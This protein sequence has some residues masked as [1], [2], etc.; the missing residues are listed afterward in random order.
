MI[1]VSETTKRAYFDDSYDKQIVIDFENE[2]Q[3]K[4]DGVN[5]YHGDLWND[6][7]SLTG[8]G[9][10][11]TLVKF[12]SNSYSD[13]NN[14]SNYVK[15]EYFKCRKKGNI[16]FDLM[17]FGS[18]YVGGEFRLEVLYKKNDGKI[19]QTN[20]RNE[21]TDD[22]YGKGIKR[23]CL[24]SRYLNDCSQIL[25]IRIRNM[26]DHYMKYNVK[27]GCFGIFA[28]N[29]IVTDEYR[30]NY[31]E[32]LSDYSVL[33]EPIQYDPSLQPLTNENLKAESFSLTESLCSADNLK[34]GLCESSFCEFSYYGRSEKFR[35]KTINVYQ[36][37]IDNTNY[38]QG[39]VPLGRFKITSSQKQSSGGT[40]DARKIVAYDGLLKLE[41]NAADWYTQYMF[42]VNTSARATRFGFEYARQIFSTY[43]N[44]A[45]SIGIEEDADYGGVERI[46]YRPYDSIEPVD[47]FSEPFGTNRKRI[48]YGI[49][50]CITA[51][52]R[53]FYKVKRS[54]WMFSD[55][56]VFRDF[57]DGYKEEIDSLGRG[58]L[59]KGSILIEEHR[60]SGFN[61]FVVDADDWFAIHDDTDYFNVYVTKRTVE[62][63]GTPLR[64]ITEEVEVYESTKE[65]NLTNAACRL[66]YYNWSS[67]EIF[68]CDSSITGR[69]VIRS[70]LEVCGCFYKLDRYGK[71]QFKY[72]TK[73]ALYPSETLYPK[74]TLFTRGYEGIFKNAQ[75][76]KF[77]CEDYTVQDYGKI[78]IK[79]NSD[80]N[81]TKSIVEWQYVGDSNKKNAYI[82]EDNIFYCHS[83]MEYEYDS[84]AEVSEMLENMYLRIADMGYVPHD[85]D[86]VGMPYLECG[87]R[88]ILLTENGGIETFIFSRNLSGIQSMQDNFEAKGDEYNEQ[89]NDFGYSEWGNT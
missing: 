65:N 12:W 89:I 61:R 5:L 64:R 73:S 75:Y 22:F 31:I 16:I 77:D 28:T 66:M 62:Q 27:V 87:D 37:L 76:I 25:E 74:D 59:N 55:D 15:C 7:V 17:I 57:L 11:N 39:C 34:F 6:T 14:F 2:N 45:K 70:L 71:P 51:N 60:T 86:A 19:Y 88:I 58:A 13:L 49:G 46:A 44:F 23:Y 84:M 54:N 33:G 72:C 68:S 42:G 83:A 85:T 79:K 69:D 63:D 29:D 20:F 36:K 32:P 67:C 56:I 78:Q 9:E 35:G 1:D 52:P 40:E 3:S 10:K 80:S 43:Y 82:I 21:H 38:I 30:F 24:I 18:E 8:Y 48:Q 4:V 26:S 41:E 47:M 53:K 50:G 81:E